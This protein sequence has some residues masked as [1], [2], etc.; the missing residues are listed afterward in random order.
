MFFRQT[1]QEDLEFVRQNPFEG[2]VKNYPYMQV[3]DNNCYTVI[4]EGQIVAVGG[5]IVLWEGV[6]ELWLMLTAE[7]R[8][9]GIFGVIALSAIRDKV[10]ELIENNNIRRAQ[11]MIRTDFPQAIKMIESFGF[12]REGLLEQ[13]CPDKGDVYIYAQIMKGAK[14]GHER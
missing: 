9:N 4:F 5:M 12:R 13:Y 8:K 14:Y 3:P 10:E 11:S 6:G 7:C 2:A 1:T